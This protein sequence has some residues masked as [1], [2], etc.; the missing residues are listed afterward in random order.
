MVYTFPAI[1]DEAT[2]E[3]NMTHAAR[4]VFT[5]AGQEVNSVEEIEYDMKLVISMGEGFRERIPDVFV[6]KKDKNKKTPARA[7]E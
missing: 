4:R 2:T 3:L 1:L 5:M 7:K 6:D